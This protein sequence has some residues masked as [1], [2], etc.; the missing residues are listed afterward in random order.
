MS[1]DADSQLPYVGVGGVV[2]CCLGLEVLGGAVVLGGLAA[3]I[4][5][6]T[7]VTYLMV[8]GLG[9]LVALGVAVGYHHVGEL[10]DGVLG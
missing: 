10:N 6:S 8:V 5:L 9:G 1:S 4:G 2:A 3:K 7:G